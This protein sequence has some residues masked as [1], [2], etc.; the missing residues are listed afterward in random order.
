M[1][2]AA[3]SAVHLRRGSDIPQK[4]RFFRYF[5]QEITG[6]SQILDGAKKKKEMQR[7]DQGSQT[8]KSRWAGWET[9]HWLEVNKRTQSNT[10]LQA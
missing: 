6:L 4:E 9:Q 8:Y 3:P 7:A 2:E 10:S 1:A 5:R